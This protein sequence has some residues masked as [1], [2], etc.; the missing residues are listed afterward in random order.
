[1]KN[2]KEKNVFAFY[3]KHIMLTQATLF[4]LSIITFMP[5]Q[6]KPLSLKNNI[7][8]NINN[9]TL[10]EAMTTI[11][12][13]SGYKFVYNNNDVD[14]SR[15]VSIVANNKKVSD[16]VSNLFSENDVKIFGKNIVIMLKKKEAKA[17][18][19]KLL[20]KEEQ[21][22]KKRITGTVVDE[23]GVSIIGANIVEVGTTNGTVTDVDGKF[24]L[25]VDNNATIRITYIGYLEQDINTAGRNSFNVTLQEDM[26]ALDEV[27][28]V[29]YG[30]QKKVNL[31]GSV[32]S[33]TSSDI[34][35][36]TVPKTSQA[37]QGQMSG[38]TV[39]QNSGSPNANSPALMIRGKGTFSSAGTAPLVLIDGMEGGIDDVAPNDIESISLLK[40]ASSASIYGSKAANGVILI[41]TKRGKEGRTVINYR[42]YIGKA[43][44][45]MVPD[46]VNSWE[47]AEAKN[48]A[49]RNTG[50]SS[51]YSAE[52]IEKFRSGSDPINYPNV[53]HLK[54]LFN[55]GSG[56]DTKHDISFSGGNNRLNY[57]FSGGYYKQE[58]LIMKDIADRYDFRLNLGS[59]LKDNLTLNASLAG[60]VSEGKQPTHGEWGGGTVY[61][62]MGAQR[63]ANNI[64]GRLPDGYYGRNEVYHPEADIDSKG[65]LQ[66]ISKNF[67]GTTSLVWDITEDLSLTGRAGYKQGYN[68]SKNYT[69][70]YDVTPV[71]NIP[72]NKLTQTW[73]SNT[74]LLMEAMIN[75][76]LRL[77]DHTLRFLGGTSAQSYDYSYMTGFRN[78]F[79][80]DLLYELNAGT[81]SSQTNGGSASRNKLLSYFG[82]INYDYLEKYLLEA[83]IRYDGSSRFPK[84][85]RW[86]LFPSF[87]AGWRVS[88]EEFFKEALPNISNLKIRGSWGE[89]GNQ[90][91]GNYPYQPLITLGQNYP[92]AETMSPGAAVVT[93]ASTDITW[94]TTVVTDLGVD[95]G[96]FNNS[97]NFTADY[98]IK[99]TRD[100]L[101]NVATSLLIGARTPIVNAGKVENRGWDFNLSYNKKFG[102]FSFGATGI[103]SINHNEV[104]ELSSGLTKNIDSGLFVGHPIGSRYGYRS[105]GLFTTDAEV[106]DA[107]TQPH[108][109]LANAGGIKYVDL[110]GPD[111]VPDG[112]VNN[113]YDREI[114]GQIT[115]IT[116]YALTIDLGYKDFDLSMMLQGEGGRNDMV[117]SGFFFPLDNDANVQKDYYDNRWT[118]DNPD[119][120]AKYPKLMILPAN[121]YTSNGR[122]TDFWFRD[123]TFLRLKNLQI[124]YT[125]SEN[126]AHKLFC[127]NIRI[128]LSGDNLFTLSNYYQGWDPESNSGAQYALTKTFIGGI[129]INF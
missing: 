1:M 34:D 20:P 26:K 93:L 75:Y 94:E 62:I 52:D 55:S 14:V 48:E 33:I 80:N 88:E 83:N 60:Y 19:L 84:D 23:K 105:D 49:L 107:P 113:A 42:G 47:F 50:Q 2:I 51:I 40:D 120:N 90:S 102:D 119:P 72:Q 117:M 85:N 18:S 21:Q 103:L 101:Y 16:I 45:T 111:G 63:L 70:R 5:L 100:I 10:L 59:K 64:P 127:N 28:V 30:T 74:S 65:F 38:I 125:L 76:N 78:N 25:S 17:E 108:A 71:Y 37:L 104:L 99:T 122:L 77:Q 36:R 97:L 53:F 31:T 58:G 57:L 3:K 86:G 43:R 123:A 106:A 44:P 81:S 46:V 15:K 61:I 73:S 41:E 96:F 7:D 109:F 91:V 69:A 92:F 95:L 22:A 116:T 115:P 27:V 128:Y 35:K 82:R 121:F 29:G 56:M 68:H 67:S 11:E 110:S 66:N 8:I 118:A 6:A 54:D 13:A 87:S 79:P 112:K 114:I 129:N 24:S 124:G 126:I 89:L 4:L 32:S 12:K 9:V 39:T 98:Y